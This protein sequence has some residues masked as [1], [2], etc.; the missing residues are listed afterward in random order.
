MVDVSLQRTQD[1]CAFRWVGSES[2]TICLELHT[3]EEQPESPHR[4][5]HGKH[6]ERQEAQ[7]LQTETHSSDASSSGPA[8]GPASWILAD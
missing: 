4:C 7:G 6:R 8:A 3:A 2:E 1:V 5:D